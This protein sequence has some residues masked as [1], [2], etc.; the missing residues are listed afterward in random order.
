MPHQRFGFKTAAGLG[1]RQAQ[2]L[3]QCGVGLGMPTRADLHQTHHQQRQGFG[4]CHAS[5]TLQAALRHHFG[6]SDA[7]QRLQHHCQIV[8]YGDAAAI[9]RVL[10]QQARQRVMGCLHLA[11]KPMNLPFK[12][13]QGRLL[14]GQLGYQTPQATQ[15]RPRHGNVGLAHGQLDQHFAGN[16]RLLVH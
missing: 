9:V 4:V 3:R 1:A 16:H 11:A 7:P 2:G 5:P 13:Q 10:R 8:F 14:G 15:Q 12:T 6:F